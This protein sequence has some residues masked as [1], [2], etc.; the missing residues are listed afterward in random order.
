MDTRFLSLGLH[1]LREGRSGKKPL[2]GMG[3]RGLVKVGGMERY[4]ISIL[5]IKNPS[6]EIG[7]MLIGCQADA[8]QSLSTDHVWVQT[9]PMIDTGPKSRIRP[10]LPVSGSRPTVK[11]RLG[12]TT[13]SA[14]LSMACARMRWR[15]SARL[16]GHL[17]FPHSRWRSAPFAAA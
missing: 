2:Q 17:W 3:C 8:D 15:P 7:Y 11:V 5:S 1:P 16:F 10:G 14:R 9:L 12:W 6:N 13:R 4:G